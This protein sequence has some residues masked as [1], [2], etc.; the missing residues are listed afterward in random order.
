MIWPHTPT[1]SILVIANMFPS[2]EEKLDELATTSSRSHPLT[3]R[4]RFAMDLVGPSGVVSKDFNRKVD[5]HSG[6]VQ[7]LSVVQ[8]L[9]S[10]QIVEVTFH[11]TG[12]LVQQLAPLRGVHRA[13]GRAEF[14][15][16]HGRGN[17]LVNIGLDS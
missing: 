2:K 4:N 9:E 5:V 17:R 6:F 1:G 14:E 13:P 7:R 3:S 11:Q 15:G 8:R 10:G 16:C 12:Q